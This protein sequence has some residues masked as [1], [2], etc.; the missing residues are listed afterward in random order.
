MNAASAPMPTRTTAS[1]AHAS[2][3]TPP[4]GAMAELFAAL[5][6]FVYRSE[7]FAEDLPLHLPAPAPCEASSR[8]WALLSLPG[9]LGLAAG[10]TLLLGGLPA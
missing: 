5:P 4:D 1:A 6:S 3:A 7:A 8:R 10:L 9:A 2:S